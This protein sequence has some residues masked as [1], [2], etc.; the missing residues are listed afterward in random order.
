[1][2]YI[3]TIMASIHFKKMQANRNRI[4]V[5]DAHVQGHIV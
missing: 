4:E 2:P 1:M 5:F 3:R